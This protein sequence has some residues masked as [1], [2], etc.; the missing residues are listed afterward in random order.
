MNKKNVYTNPTDPSICFITAL[1]IYFSYESISL[2]TREGIFLKENTKLGTA[3]HR[4]CNSLQKL[5]ENYAEV[6]DGYVHCSQVNIPIIRK[7]SATYLTRGIT[8]HPSLIS[9]TL[10]GEW[11]TGK[12]FD[13]YLTLGNMVIITWVE[14][15]QV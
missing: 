3:A 6:V 13:V 1:G 10:C 4:F 15:W 7:G 12:V 2:V 14:F 8:V 9:V 5:I 11:N